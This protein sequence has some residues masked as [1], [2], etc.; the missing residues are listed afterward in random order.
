LWQRRIPPIGAC[1]RNADDRLVNIR[2]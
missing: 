2:L 1:T